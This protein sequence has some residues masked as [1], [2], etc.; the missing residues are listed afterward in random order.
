[1][2]MNFS[3][4][5]IVSF[6][7]QGGQGMG[8]VLD[9]TPGN[10]QFS[11][12]ETD[13]GEEIYIGLTGV[14]AIKKADT[15]FSA[16]DEVEPSGQNDITLPKSRLKS[17]RILATWEEGVGTLRSLVF[18]GGSL[19]AE[20]GTVVIYLPL[21]LEDELRSKVGQKIAIIRTDD[22]IRPYR[23]RCVGGC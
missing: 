11:G 14:Q 20:I 10:A 16:L 1:M 21:E 2:K 22:S 5:D 23:I 19:V 18:D 8:T 6:S 15:D 13:D 17:G 9:D 7:V 4:G 3:R 12:I